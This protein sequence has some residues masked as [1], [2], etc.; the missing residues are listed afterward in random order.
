MADDREEKCGN[1]PCSC[2]PQSGEKYCGVVCEGK[3]ET[4]E[5]DCDCGH[6]DCSGNF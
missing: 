5:L 3:G 4:I 2:K 6:P 1:A